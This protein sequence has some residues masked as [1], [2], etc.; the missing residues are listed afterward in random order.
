MSLLLSLESLLTPE[1]TGKLSMELWYLP[2][3][4]VT[5]EDRGEA[6]KEKRKN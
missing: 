2:T 1:A 5:T 6:L 3:I 4:T